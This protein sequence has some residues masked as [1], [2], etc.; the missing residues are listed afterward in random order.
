MEVHMH[1]LSIDRHFSTAWFNVYNR[2]RTLA[3]ACSPR[4]TLLI[5]LIRPFFLRQHASEI[6]QVDPVE[7]YE[8]VRIQVSFAT[9]KVEYVVIVL[10]GKLRQIVAQMVFVEGILLQRV[11]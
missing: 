5:D 3:L 6:E 7:L 9:C 4:A 10:L 2:P 1:R 11:E 8:V